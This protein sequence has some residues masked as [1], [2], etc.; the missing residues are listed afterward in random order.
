[1]PQGSYHKKVWS[2]WYNHFPLQHQNQETGRKSPPLSQRAF[3]F[4]DFSS[5]ENFWAFQVFL[6][7]LWGSWGVASVYGHSYCLPHLTLTI[8]FSSAACFAL[9]NT[10]YEAATPPCK[11]FINRGS[12]L[13]GAQNIHSVL[14]SS[15]NLK[16]VLHSFRMVCFQLPPLSQTVQLTLGKILYFPCICLG[17]CKNFSSFLFVSWLS[18]ERFLWGN[19]RFACACGLPPSLTSF[20]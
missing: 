9:F 18:R 7:Q 19:R 13:E 12:K 2:R 3:S 4:L 10:F 17:F 11:V 1:M 6:K 15:I 8:Q 5:L 16:A 20:I 14:Q